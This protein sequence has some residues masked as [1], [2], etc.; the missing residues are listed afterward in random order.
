MREG[1]ECLAIHKNQ[2]WINTDNVYI[3]GSLFVDG[4]KITGSSSGGGGSSYWSLN[5]NKLETSSAVKSI[6]V[7][8][9]GYF[10]GGETD[11][12]TFRE[13]VSTIS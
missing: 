4:N 6:R 1:T 7:D 5:G 13:P 12:N 3:T 2:T 8:G 10:T 11:F 9:Y